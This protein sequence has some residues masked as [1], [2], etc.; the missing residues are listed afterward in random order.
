MDCRHNV[1]HEIEKSV[2]HRQRSGGCTMSKVRF[3]N[4]SL[5]KTHLQRLVGRKDI[6]DKQPDLADYHPNSL[7]LS[8]QVIF[9]L[10]TSAYATPRIDENRCIIHNGTIPTNRWNA[11]FVIDMVPLKMKVQPFIKLH[12]NFGIFGEVSSC[13]RIT[14]A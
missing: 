13:A 9:L 2:A 10:H 4:V 3:S 7:P 11:T 5:G 1:Y 8:P 12:R 14:N 6:K